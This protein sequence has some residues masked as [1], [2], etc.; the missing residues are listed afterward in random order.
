MY[1]QGDPEASGT[2]SRFIN[3]A[4]SFEFHTKLSDREIRVII[5]FL[6]VTLTE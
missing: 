3:S 5:R 2:V 4:H 1:L 6:L